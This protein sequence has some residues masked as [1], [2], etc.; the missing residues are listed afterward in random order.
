MIPKE[1]KKRRKRKKGK[2]TERPK[3]VA[4]CLS[5][6]LLQVFLTTFLKTASVILQRE[7]L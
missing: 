2:K 7:L 3:Y 1:R 4:W 5:M 6:E